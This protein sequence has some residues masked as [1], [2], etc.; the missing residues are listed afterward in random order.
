M[1]HSSFSRTS[2]NSTPITDVHCTNPVI[3]NKRSRNDQKKTFKNTF[4][5]R[6]L[7]TILTI[8]SFQR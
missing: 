6:E 2:P 7:P 1:I 4:K 5:N 3:D 8:W